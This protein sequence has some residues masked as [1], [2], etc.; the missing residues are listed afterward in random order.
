MN[1]RLVEN[2]YL[3]DVEPHSAAP[4]DGA[5]DLRARILLH[6]LFCDSLLI[7]DSQSLNNRYFRLL[8]TDH[9]KTDED[10]SETAGRQLC[11]LAPLLT[12]G[13]IRVALRTGST[14]HEIRSD[15]AARNVDNVPDP[16]YVDGLHAMT[17][18]R[19]V[20]YDGTAVSA[21][22]KQGV[23]DRIDRALEHARG[24]ALSTLRAVRDWAGEQ[25]PLEYKAIRDR[26]A[27]HRA[28]RPQAGADVV[29]ALQ[30]VDQWAGES[31]RQALP[32]ALGA[33]VAAPRDEVDALPEASRRPLLELRGLAPALLDGL[34]LSLLP[35]DVLLDA[36]AQPSR[37]ALVGE[38]ARIRRGQ[39]PDIGVLG[40][41]AEEFSAWTAEACTR[42]FRAQGGR[43]WHHLQGEERLMR[44]GVDEDPT[45][46]RLGA[47]LELVHAPGSRAAA[48]SLH[49]LSSASASAAPPTVP[50]PR[51][52]LHELDPLRRQVSL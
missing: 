12:E 42:V 8:V 51:R 39:Q 7:G 1:V 36:V 6:V 35:V 19:V 31:Y 14:L 34:L 11:D 17:D 4:I 29:L 38:L 25:Q 18:G 16:A 23:L 44:L 2:V 41:A 49:V 52:P 21:A 26:L 40:S 47:G 22:F 15:H 48:L 27:D 46:G 37:N 9:Q 10:G 5:A 45:A 33:A 28:G 32:W 43:A 30:W 20:P 50:R 3:S 24:E 13:R